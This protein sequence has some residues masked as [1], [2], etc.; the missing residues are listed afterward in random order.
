MLLANV[1]HVLNIIGSTVL[2]LQ[3][4]TETRKSSLPPFCTS[5]M[6]SRSSRRHFSLEKSPHF[7]LLIEL[8][9]RH[10]TAVPKYSRKE[11]P[12][13]ISV[14][15]PVPLISSLLVGIWICTGPRGESSV[16]GCCCFKQWDVIRQ[17]AV[18][19]RFAFC[20]FFFVF[21]LSLPD[22]DVRW[23][24][25]MHAYSQ[26]GEEPKSVETCITHGHFSLLST[27]RMRINSTEVFIK[28]SRQYYANN[29]GHVSCKW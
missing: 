8:N 7:L 6:Q 13:A 24:H 17:P 15:F 10:I 9:R 19:C 4:S 22:I 20:F 5:I 1:V 2:K 27:K 28:L 16:A 21:F 25:L 3:R 29:L 23:M 18:Y 11:Y 14:S 12:G 26:I